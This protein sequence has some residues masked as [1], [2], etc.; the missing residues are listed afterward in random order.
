[1]DVM[2]LDPT[3]D[4]NALVPLLSEWGESAGGYA[5]P[6]DM[7][8]VLSTLKMFTS[9]KGSAVLVLVDGESVK[10]FMGIY[11]SSNHLGRG[12]IARECLYFVSQKARRHAKRLISAAEEWAKGNGCSHLVLTASRLANPELFSRVERFY[13]ACEFSIFETSFIKEIH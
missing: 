2:M 1:M 10:G 11:R 6:M 4:I 8:S 5:M 3:D 13:A 9:K 12:H 7:Q